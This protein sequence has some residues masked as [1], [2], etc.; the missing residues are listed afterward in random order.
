MQ[1][2]RAKTVLLVDDDS[3][4]RLVGSAFLTMLGCHVI[5]ADVVERLVQ[6]PD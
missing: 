4:V 3:V 5:E 6:R 1:E 2:V